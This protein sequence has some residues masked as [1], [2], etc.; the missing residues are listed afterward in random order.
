MAR[1]ARA[2]EHATIETSEPTDPAHDAP[3]HPGQSG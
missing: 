2:D 1:D 3:K